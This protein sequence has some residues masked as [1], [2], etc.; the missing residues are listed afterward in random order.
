MREEFLILFVA[1]TIVY[2][3]QPILIF[4]QQAPHRPVAEVTIVSRI[5]FVPDGFR[6]NTK[7]GAAIQF[8]IAGIDGI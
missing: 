8:K 4:N 5:E 3:D 1:D 7:H 6:N 2:Q